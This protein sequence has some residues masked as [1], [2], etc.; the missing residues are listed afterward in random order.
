MV[1]CVRSDIFLQNTSFLRCDNI[2]ENPKK[3][4]VN[5]S[6]KKKIKSS[7]PTITEKGHEMKFSNEMKNACKTVCLACN[8]PV[9]LTSLREH[10]RRKH[11]LPIEDY[12]KRYGNPKDNILEIIYHKCGICARPILLNSDDIAFH[13]RRFHK[14]SHKEY[15]AK[16]MVMVVKKKSKEKEEVKICKKQKSSA[17]KVQLNIHKQDISL[18]ERIKSLKEVDINEVSTQHLLSLIDEVLLL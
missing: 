13:L 6:L 17:G 11:N 8:S 1:I 18:D 4:T 14:I 10:T 9:P 3:I 15:N 16:Y 2:Q 12:R 7:K 5:S